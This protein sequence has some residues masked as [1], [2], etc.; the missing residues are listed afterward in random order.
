MEQDL[1][2]EN[3]VQCNEFDQF[4]ISNKSGYKNICLCSLNLSRIEFKYSLSKNYYSQSMFQTPSQISNYINRCR[5]WIKVWQPPSKHNLP[6]FSITTYNILAQNLL[7]NHLYLYEKNVKSNLEWLQRSDRLKQEL[8][9]LN[10]DI[11]CLQEVHGQHFNNRILPSLEKLGYRSIFLQKTGPD[12]HDGCCILFKKNKFQLQDYMEIP[13]NRVDISH[14]LNRDQVALA[15]KI[16]PINSLKS[17]KDAKLIIANTHLIFNPKRGDIKLAQIRLLLAEIER[18][19]RRNKKDCEYYPIIFCGDFNSE[20]H[21]PLVKFIQT[22]QINLS[23]LK[24]GDISGQKEGSDQGFYFRPNDLILKGI[25][26]NGCLINENKE[27]ESKCEYEDLIIRHSL[28]LKSVYPTVDKFNLKLVST[29]TSED[30]AL[31]DHL[32]YSNE[33][34]NLRL[35]AFKQ[36]MNKQNMKKIGYIPNVILGSD[37]ISL[38]AKFFLT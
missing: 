35:S 7:L 36:L 14:T 3:C 32:F 27:N 5:H 9:E 16:C 12:H 37:H 2:N 29:S 22:G 8:I 4:S 26:S 21:S 1:S 30:C 19:A 28:N 23:G 17:K 38:S 11:F 33:H 24:S 13:F 10:S 6:E 18:F 20:P 31:V 34:P 25:D 15:I